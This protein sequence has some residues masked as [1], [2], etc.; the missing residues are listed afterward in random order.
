MALS[1]LFIGG[2]GTISAAC[3]RL[4]V[5]RGIDLTLLNRGV[6]SGR[7]AIAG[8]ES[9]RA[10]ARD[11]ASIAA[12]LQGRE[13]DVVVNFRAF[14]PE[15]VAADIDVFGGSCG[16]YVFIS[17]ASAYQKPL[18]R[19][20]ITE[21]TPLRNPYSQY[22]RDK[23]ACEDLLVAAYRS[24]G[25]PATIV[26][27]SHTYDESSVP[28][29]GGW[30]TIERMRRG[31]PVLVHG[32]GTSLWTL[33]HHTDFARAFVGLLGHPAAVGETVHITSDEVLTW[34]EI[35]RT[36][37]RAAGA[38][39]TLVHVASDTIA[40]DFPEW[41]PGLVG[42]KAHSVIFDNSKVK[43]LVPGW[44]ATVPFWQGARQIVEWF[45]ADGSRRQND[46]ALD[47]R[48]DALIA[49]VAPAGA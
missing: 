11:R 33:T 6:S 5:E 37:G 7:P 39:P 20:P 4:A 28:L 10:D 47:A 43:A 29:E 32:D 45:D 16:Q 3:S 40:A 27:P 17:S 41:G 48:V 24:S 15:Q 18:S 35:Y 49:R 34:N 1:A 21:S 13:F 23:I 26:R 25:F 31:M 2:N 9:V 38:L 22:A 46:P 44:V 36:L 12:A 42:D 8:A 19:L 14:V 30:P